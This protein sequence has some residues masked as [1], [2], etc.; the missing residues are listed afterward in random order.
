[1][2]TASDIGIAAGLAD[3]G[4]P[5]LIMIEDSVVETT[6]S[7]I[8]TMLA[9]A[10]DQVKTSADP[11]PLIA[12]GGGAF[13]VP[14][15]IPGIT[16]VIKPPNS[17]VANAVGAALAQVGGEAEI[18]YS[19]TGEDRRDA[20]DRVKK[21]ACEKAISMGAV[22]GTVQIISIEETTL[23]YMA[24]DSVRLKAKAVGDLRIT[25]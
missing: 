19:K 8:R 22:E 10:I 4:D 1:M 13:L 16:E 5:A 11:L 15:D 17:A 12:V 18:I 7:T 3:F 24:D 20:H 6:L 9:E 14:D 25:Q 21:L 2:M 23:A